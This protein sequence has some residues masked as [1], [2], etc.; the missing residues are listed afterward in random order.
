MINTIPENLFIT[1]T[2]FDKYFIRLFYKDYVLSKEYYPYQFDGWSDKKYY[3]IVDNNSNII[4]PK[5][6]YLKL[7]TNNLGTQQKNLIFVVDAFKDLKKYYE[8]IQKINKVN[9]SSIYSKLNVVESTADVPSI[10]L[11]FL[12]SLYVIFKNNFLLYDVRNEIKNID[13]FIPYFISFV[14]YVTKV[15][16]LNRSKFIGSS[17]MPQSINGLRI[18]FDKPNT[19]ADLKQLTNLY[20]N[21]SEFDRF[22]ETVAKFGF[23][24]D[25]N[26]PWDIVADLESPVMKK[27][28]K[29][30]NLNSTEQ[31]LD[32]CYHKAYTADLDTLNNILL[33]FWNSYVAEQGVS[34]QVRSIQNCASAFS[35]VSALNQLT[36]DNFTKYYNT[37]WQLRLYFFTR[38]LEE[39]INI[40][41]NKFEILY[42]ECI[43]INKM[44]DTNKALEYI[45]KKLSELVSRE[46]KTAGLTTEEEV[47]KVI[48]QQVRKL[49]QEGLIF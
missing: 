13:N 1:D 16:T 40:T 31:I 29:N 27:Y 2:T 20:I 49:P 45:N 14:K 23:Y 34:T 43:T 37:N 32:T 48:S 28:A 12:E 15:V 26:A 25:K 3:G 24:V 42:G 41:Q 9:S 33:S 47:I 17:R 6:S 39:K 8:D 44:Y 36:I 7:Y 22:I 5:Q 38:I 30:Y 35:E 46:K 19:N 10:Y 11:K 4:Y 18:S 21:N